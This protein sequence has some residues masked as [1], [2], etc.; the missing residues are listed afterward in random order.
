MKTLKL[1]L[2]IITAL[3]MI[4]SAQAQSFLTNGLV[5]YFPFNGN[6]NDAVGTNNGTV[7]GAILSTNRFGQANS[8]YLFNG[9]SSYIDLGKPA[10]LAFTNN[11]TLSAW[12]WFNGGPNNP[13][14]IC[15]TESYGY[16]LL[17]IGTGSLR[18]FSYQIGNSVFQT[19]SSFSQN[20]WHS[21]ALVVTNGFATIYVDG[22]AAG[23]GPTGVPNIYN[24]LYIG[25]SDGI[26]YWGGLI[27]DV[28]FY[29][30]A[31]SSND[32]AQLYAFESNASNNFAI[33]INLTNT[34]VVLSSNTSFTVSATGSSPI[35][36]QWYFSPTNHAGQAGAYAQ[37][38]F[39]FA[40]GAVVT[41]GGF[42]YGNVPAVS[43][44]GG[45]GSGASGYGIISNGMLTGITVTNAGSGY[46]TLPA[47]VIGPPNGFL[48]GQTNNTLNVVNANNNDIGSYYVVVSS[49]GY[50]I[51][52][53]VVTLNILY[54]PSIAQG[55]QD[56]YA[57]AYDN[58]GF[59]VT[60]GGTTPFTYSWFFNNTNSL[61]DTGSTLIV[62]NITQSNLGGYSVIVDNAYGSV[63]SSVANL[64]MYPY[65]EQPF[66]GAVTYWGQTNVLSVGAWGSG[67]LN[68]QW[69]FNGVAIADATGSTLELD[70]IQFTN[71]GQ[72]SVVVSS[73]LG[74]VTNP[75]YA[76]VVNPANVSIAIRPDV[77]IQGTVGY[78]YLIQSTTNLS[79]PSW[80]T[81]TNIILPTPMFDW[82]DLN[83]DTSKPGNPHKFYQ[84]LPGQ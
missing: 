3:T 50:S 84:V 83:V 19:A 6:A 16:D 11:F 41:N 29:K 4:T 5:S 62:S 20:N 27:D 40:V 23:T 47:V 8:A 55:P 39:G 46:T 64:Y 78:S 36:Y 22:V 18:P 42:G 68:Y 49:G 80:V 33:A 45:G 10:G 77:I 15:Y 60:A 75:P 54:P 26:D 34:S 31:L 71:A 30:R 2:G 12:C 9:S 35:T 53:S 38:T 58:A 43:F 73:S 72:Y 66:A 59:S 82:I 37:I 28:R 25:R 81:E 24:D 17:T 65:L 74:S 32:V 21:V 56:V 57:N 79:N 69:Y 7:Y 51:T 67:V 44:V 70:S 13:R 48:Y 14:I 52:S 61:N 63:T 1:T 76:V